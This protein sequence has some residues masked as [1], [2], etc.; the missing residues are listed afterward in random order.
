MKLLPI[1]LRRTIKVGKLTL[2]SPDGTRETF[3]QAD[4]FPPVTIKVNDKSLDWRIPLNPELHAA[5]AYMDGTLE[6]VEGN[7]YDFLLSFYRNRRQFDRTPGQIF[8]SGLSRKIRRFQQHNPVTKARAHVKHHYDLKDEL[9]DLFLDEDKQYSCAYFPT[10][11]ET[12]E[13]AQA[14][15]RR[16]I[17]NKLNLKDGQ[18]VLDIGSG[19][20][21]LALEIASRADVKVTGITLS[22]NQARIARQRADDAG[23]GDRV[24][25][26]IQDYREIDETFDRVVSVGMLEHVGARHLKEYFYTVRNCLAPNG[27][28]L[29]HSIS[30]KSPPG[31]TG[32]FIR[33][34]IFPNGYSPSLSEILSAVELSGLWTLDLEVLRRHYGYT[35]REWRKRFEANRSEAVDMYDEKFARMWEFYLAASEGV[36]MHGSANV[37]QLQLGREAEGVPITRDY[38]YRDQY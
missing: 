32:P 5:E 11:R 20:G 34:Y 24:K 29:I 4:E 6:V 22:D 13:E 7:V 38:L 23:V 30:T 10:G 18:T 9:F 33:K 31:I 37:V 25:F 26:I 8:W 35:L 16:H 15:K 1:L 12:L 3:G 14:A 21:G 19:W 2:I 27:V 28:A 17:I 36:F